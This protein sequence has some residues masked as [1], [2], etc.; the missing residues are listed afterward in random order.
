[1]DNIIKR[2]ILNSLNNDFSR[3]RFVHFYGV[4]GVGKSTLLEQ[5]SSD[6]SPYFVLYID[7]SNIEQNNVEQLKDNVIRIITESGIDNKANRINKDTIL[8]AILD[9]ATISIGGTN[10]S[11]LSISSIVNSFITKIYNNYVT[12]INNTSYEKLSIQLSQILIEIL[13]KCNKPIVILL[14]NVQ[15]LDQNTAIFISNILKNNIIYSIVATSEKLEDDLLTLLPD[16]INNKILTNESIDIEKYEIEEFTLLETCDYMCKT[17]ELNLKVKDKIVQNVQ[18][19]TSGLPLLVS[20]LV[21]VSGNDQLESLMFSSD[22]IN[23]RLNAIFSILYKSLSNDSKKLLFVLSICGGRIHT[24]TVRN[25]FPDLNLVETIEE[26]VSKK[27]IIEHESDIELKYKILIDIIKQS[28]SK[29]TYNKL[30]IYEV[31]VENITFYD[32]LSLQ[33]LYNLHCSMEQ[34]ESALEI[35]PK[36]CEK[37]IES[38]NYNICIQYIEKEIKSNAFNCLKEQSKQLLCILLK[39]YYYTNQNQKCIE[40]FLRY[41]DAFLT[42]SEALLFISQAA[43]YLND[44]ST[45]IK[46]CNKIYTEC[47]SNIFHKKQLLLSSSYDLC[48]EYKKSIDAYTFGKK[49]A[50]SEKDEYALSLY[51][52]SIQMVS[53]SYDECISALTQGVS[54]FEQYG[55]YRNVACINNNIGIEMLMAGI[56]ESKSF[57]EKSLQRFYSSV[58]VETQFPLNNLGLYYVLIEKDYEKARDYFSRALNAAVSPLQYC[59]ILNNLAIIECILANNSAYL[60]FEKAIEYADK[61]PDPI[62]KAKAY[63]N[64]YKFLRMEGYNNYQKALEKGILNSFHP[65]YI[66][67]IERYS[68]ELKTDKPN[69][70]KSMISDRRKFFNQLEWLWGELMFYN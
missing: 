8:K 4:Y 40:I 12:T 16:S 30:Q 48:G 36:L 69:P 35:L 22:Y 62:V 60:I 70:Y 9:S 31:L 53:T 25:A 45:T 58:G 1:M 56:G 19:L 11:T 26:L 10:N 61:C 43:Y 21:N 24:K 55:E 63:Y 66:N 49:R 14:D 68:E 57:L 38:Y 51:C 46:L 34:K 27:I 17:W 13:E 2:T 37:L 59:Y 32:Y 28:Y 20:I 44:F 65:Q 18:H 23:N 33:V 29:S 39:S 50:E 47:Q 67:I 6:L 5:L 15:Y 41:K 52:L 42:N 7:I 54:I 3:R 64:R